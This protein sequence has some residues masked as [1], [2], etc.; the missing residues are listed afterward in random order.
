M[1]TIRKAE[2]KDLH[3]ITEIYN[4]AVLRTTAT[5]DTTTK[6]VEEQRDWY[7][8]HGPKYPI[9]V[10]QEDSKVI[11]WA[12]LSAASDRC[13]YS[14]TAEGSIYIDSECQGKGV[15]KKLGAAIMKAGKEA[16][17]HTVILKIAEGNEASMKL[18]KSLGFMKI[19]VMKEVGKKFGKFL[20]VT[21]LQ[22]IYD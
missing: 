16:G 15:G 4:Q 17:L 13:A 20:D 19:G 3:A 18:A 5:F 14:G 21:M 22:L 12:S 11:G 9:L 8:K 1:L 7:D 2:I 10:V 6:T